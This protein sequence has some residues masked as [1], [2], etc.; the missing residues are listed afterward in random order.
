MNWFIYNLDLTQYYNELYD[1]G[2]NKIPYYPYKT[3]AKTVESN[4][5]YHK[6][7]KT[8]MLIYTEKDGCFDIPVVKSIISLLP[9]TPNTASFI[10]LNPYVVMPIHRDDK[11]LRKS[12]LII[13]I[14]PLNEHYTTTKFYDEDKNIIDEAVFSTKPVIINT[15]ERHGLQNNDI[16]RIQ[17][18]LGFSEGIE[19]WHDLFCRL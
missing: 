7:I 2:L 5:E 4:P 13:P 14:Y 8:D 18:N 12:H 11:V 6:S 10:K 15:Q 17:F 1:V 19:D 3:T 9:F 16:V